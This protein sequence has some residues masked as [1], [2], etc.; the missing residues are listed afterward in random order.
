[1]C[2]VRGRDVVRTRGR[3][4]EQAALI[5][6]G[7]AAK[8][9]RQR[10]WSKT[11]APYGSWK[12]PIT[13]ELI[14]AQ[15]ISLTDVPHRRRTDLLARGPA[16]GAGPLCG[17]ARALRRR[18]A[19]R[20]APAPSTSARGCTSTA[21]APGC[22]GRHALFS[23]FADGRLLPSDRGRVH[24]S[25]SRASAR[26]GRTAGALPTVSS[27]QARKRWIGYARTTPAAPGKRSTRDQSRSRSAARPGRAVLA[28]GTI[29]SL[30][31]ACRPTEAGCSGL[32]GSS[33]HAVER[34][35]AL[36]R[37][38][39]PRRHADRCAEVDRGGAAGVR[40]SSR[41][42]RPTAARFSS[43]R[44]A[45]AGGICIATMSRG[46]EGARGCH[47]WRRI[48]PAQWNFGMSTYAFAGPTGSCALYR[49]MGSGSL[50][51][52]RSHVGRE[53]RAVDMPFTEDRRGAP[54]AT[55]WRFSAAR[56]R[57][58]A[59]VVSSIAFRHARDR[60]EV[61]RYSRPHRRCASP[62]T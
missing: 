54:R 20:L 19:A 52:V 38:A 28:G 5:I 16:A 11:N 18:S 25:R 2:D 13:S 36:S 41:N 60:E 24:R 32:H 48:R 49:R 58:P 1:V 45:P 3:E 53:A 6:L 15:S 29:S 12:S 30:R 23:H 26:R 57:L 22:D 51:V 42:G 35:D 62:N 40:S 8:R 10:L 9:D 44:I 27:T 46:S 55:A 34:H 33:Q 47:R 56:R 31:R 21:A 59:C 4:I 61:D 17:R 37:G 43:C 50:A 39:R 14:V 7:F